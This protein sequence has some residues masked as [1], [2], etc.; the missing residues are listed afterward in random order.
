MSLFGSLFGGSSNSTY[1]YNSGVPDFRD[2]GE[3]VWAEV[4]TIVTKNG[5]HV[6][7][8]KSKDGLVHI[9]IK[10]L[11][12]VISEV[13]YMNIRQKQTIYYNENEAMMVQQLIE[14]K[15]QDPNVVQHLIDRFGVGNEGGSVVIVRLSA[16]KAT[17]AYALDVNRVIT[18]KFNDLI[19]DFNRLQ[20]AFHK[21][22]LSPDELKEATE[23]REA[24]EELYS[25][26]TGIV[27]KIGEIG[28]R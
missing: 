24:L 21:N 17:K 14:A 18:S 1:R 4:K 28:R 11:D 27:T 20:E 13:D 5:D 25:V 16:E 22:N 2:K 19:A 12:A 26:Q 3:L 15:L 6:F 8:G 9:W 23:I 7:K 10:E